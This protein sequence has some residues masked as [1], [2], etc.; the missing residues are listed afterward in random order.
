MKWLIFMACGILSI[1][2]WIICCCCTCCNCCCFKDKCQNRL[3]SFITFVLCA[4]SY[5][6]VAILGIYTAAKAN[7]AIAGINNASCSLF[8]FIEDIKNGQKRKSNVHWKGINGLIEIMKKLK[9]DIKYTYD[10]KYNKLIESYNLYTTNVNNAGQNLNSM[11]INNMND[12]SFALDDEVSPNIYPTINV[13]PSCFANFSSMYRVGFDTEYTQTVDATKTYLDDMI[14]NFEDISGCTPSGNTCGNSDTLDVIDDSIKALGD[15]SKPI[16]DIES[17]IADTWIDIQ[18]L[19]NDMGSKYLQLVGSVICVFCAGVCALIILYKLMSCVGKVFKILIIVLWN[20]VMLTTIVIFIFGGFIG[21]LGKIGTDLV[22]VMKHITSASNLQAQEPDV[23]GNIGDSSKYLI[24]CLHKDGDIA[25]ELQLTNKAQGIE[26]LNSLKNNLIQIKNSFANKE[27][28]IASDNYLKLKTDYYSNIFYYDSNTK[29]YD[30]SDNEKK[31]INEK[32][33]LCNIKEYWGFNINEAGPNYQ[34]T[35]TYPTTAQ[36][37]TFIKITD[38]DKTYYQSRYTTSS[39]TGISELSTATGNRF[40]KVTQYFDENV[41]IT[42]D[43]VN[44]WFNNV[45]SYKSNIENVFTYTKK[46]TDIAIETIETIIS[47][48]N[49]LLGNGEFWQ[50][51]NCKFMGED[52]NIMLKN[53]HSGLGKKFVNLGNTLVAMAFLEAISVS[54]TI[55]TL[56]ATKQSQQNPQ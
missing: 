28:S 47:S 30:F 23:I 45:K 4:A 37:Y 6:T 14:T 36:D 17:Q 34:E 55:V 48:I 5:A 46:T 16:D 56:H 8:G 15:I 24:T 41:G 25:T 52:L 22:L 19:I 35:T 53:I 39:C 43:D 21:L 2:G 44:D 10:N 38:I 27:N 49:G 26:N 51:L 33:D 12:Y 1:I 50:F 32:L 18:D 54:L 31:K 7:N 3:C 40:Y 9:A 13:I 29:A 20:I 11:T 42:N